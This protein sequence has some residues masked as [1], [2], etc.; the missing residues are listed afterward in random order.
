MRVLTTDDRVL[1]WWLIR[2]PFK[3]ID[4]TFIDFWDLYNDAHLRQQNFEF[5]IIRF[6]MQMISL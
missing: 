2:F 3:K 1:N 4:W 5:V 6:S